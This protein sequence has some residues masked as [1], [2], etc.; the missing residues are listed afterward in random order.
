MAAYDFTSNEL[1]VEEW[2]PIMDWPSYDISNVG[3]VRRS[4]DS[5]CYPAGLVLKPHLH[6]RYW[7]V[8]LYDHGVTRTITIHTLV[9]KAFIGP[10][11]YGYTINHKDG[12]KDN[13]RDSNLEYMT[14]QDNIAHATFHGLRGKGD[15][16]GSRTH[17]EVRPRGQSV[18]TSVL[19]DDKVRAIKDLIRQRVTYPEVAHRFNVSTS[20]IQCIASRKTWRH[21]T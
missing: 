19:T 16:N 13:N 8:C 9:A 3:R 10:R 5:P 7:V 14:V 11:P 2:R 18:K 12:C 15:T 21:I 1:R 4:V 6:R 17:P 20:C